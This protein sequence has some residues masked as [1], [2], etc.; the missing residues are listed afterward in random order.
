ML[1]STLVVDPDCAPRS[2]VAAEKESQML[3]RTAVTALLLTLSAMPAWAQGFELPGIG[4]VNTSM[5]A[6]GVAIPTDSQAALNTNP[7][8]IAKVQGNQVSFSTEFF[9]DGSHFDSRIGSYAGGSDGTIAMAVIP[10]FGWMGRM[11]DSSPVALGFGLLGV[12]G[13]RTDFA[14]DSRNPLLN[15]Q[16]NGYGRFYTDLQIAKIPFAMAMQ[17]NPKLAL[18]L[19]LNLYRGV[20]AASPLPGSPPNVSSTGALFI[21]AAGNQVPSF[22]FGVQVGA[23]Y[24]INDMVSVGASYTTPQKFQQYAWNSTNADSTSA[25]FGQNQQLTFNLDGPATLTFGVG[26][27]PKPGL[28]IGVDS[29]YVA[30]G[31]TTGIGENAGSL[32]RWRSVWA[33]M[34]GAEYW[35]NDRTALR[36]GFSYLQTPIVAERVAFSLGTPSTFQKHFSVGAGTMVAPHL[37]FDV[38]FYVVPRESVTGPVLSIADS[39]P[40]PDSE[41][42]LSNKLTSFQF[43]LNFK[44]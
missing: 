39:S 35:L 3:A 32:I 17:V 11:S 43:A 19:S 44:F 21:P 12:A 10:S 34:T 14:Q 26:L 37:G 15:P 5:G 41:V 28:R 25:S 7:A 27:T 38:G 33:V 23:L 22:G 9:K 2:A 1:Q 4:A 6:A 20:L 30:M 40:I 42:T 13:F 29:R 31:S 24:D 18:G 8:L 16:P 36:A